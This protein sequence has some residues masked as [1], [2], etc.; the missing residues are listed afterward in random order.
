VEVPAL[1]AAALTDA[2]PGETSSTV[3]VRVLA[4]RDRQTGR[5]GGDGGRVNADLQGNALRHHCHPTP[6]GRALLRS[7]T[8]R[9][10]LSA[11]SYGRVLKVARTIADLAGA[12]TVDADH[13]AEAL[14]YRL[15]D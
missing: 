12:E 7:A 3:R 1:P 14:Q 6:A 8:E 5:Y 4:A 15:V 10:A 13:L 11:R 9:L 2:P